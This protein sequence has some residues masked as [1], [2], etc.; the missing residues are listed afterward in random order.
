MQLGLNAR[1]LEMAKVKVS[2]R[3]GWIVT[4]ELQYAKNPSDF[5]ALAY[6]RR[7]HGPFSNPF[8]NI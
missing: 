4:K 8:P 5:E 6:K 1:V 3:L 2:G 7:A